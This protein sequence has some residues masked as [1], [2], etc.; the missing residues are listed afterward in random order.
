MVVL[1]TLARPLHSQILE[2]LCDDPGFVGAGFV[3]L[4]DKVKSQILEIWDRHGS[5]ISFQ[6]LTALRLPLMMTS[7]VLPVGEIPPY[8]IILPPLK[9]VT[10]SVQQSA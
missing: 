1:V 9:D 6:Y 3:I 8:T 2:V 5:R 4:E 10:R 7:S